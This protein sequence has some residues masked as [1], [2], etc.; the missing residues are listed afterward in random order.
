MAIIKKLSEDLE[1]II[2]D[3]KNCK[4]DQERVEKWINQFDDLGANKQ[5]K[6]I[7]LQE[8]IRVFK[9]TYFSKR[10]IEILL[11]DI[12][13]RYRDKKISFL[14]IQDKRKINGYKS[15]SQKDYINI[16][17]N[18][19][20]QI[21]INNFKADI[22]I[23][24]DDYV[25]SG[26]SIKKDIQYLLQNNL[27]EKT[28]FWL[29]V[30]TTNGIHQLNKDYKNLNGKVY[31]AL[32][33]RLTYKNKSDILWP[34]KNDIIYCKNYD[35]SN[36]KFREGFGE[37]KLFKNDNNKKLLEY[38]FWKAGCNIL[39]NTSDSNLLPLGAGYPKTVGSGILSATY[40]NIPNNSPICLWWGDDRENNY[41][42]P[43]MQRET[44]K[45][46]YE[47]SIIFPDWLK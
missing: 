43:L 44:N 23:Y 15:S 22:L 35:Y 2:G 40:R 42:F 14:N 45:S 36:M 17:K 47:K 13:R 4:I 30:T 37:S 11:K 1:Q 6:I 16:V 21:E 28:N 34:Y 27:L 10:K 20:P 29:L 38:Y 19:V 5:D 31:I 18:I 46:Q 3:Y 41:W 32:E 24:F 12:I 33:N 26:N 8:L 25:I 9:I 39:N 7:I